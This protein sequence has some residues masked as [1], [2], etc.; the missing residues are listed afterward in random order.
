MGF[1]ELI[2]ALKLHKKLRGGM[3]VH[4]AFFLGGS[5]RV[6]VRLFRDP[7]NLKS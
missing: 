2:K 5:F 1:M 3:C 6:P 4:A 7:V